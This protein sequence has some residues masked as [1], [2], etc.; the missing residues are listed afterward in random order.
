MCDWVLFGPQST[1]KVNRTRQDTVQMCEEC[2][3][4]HANVHASTTINGRRMSKKKITLLCVCVEKKWPRVGGRMMGRDVYAYMSYP[5]AH[6]RHAP[7]HIYIMLHRTYTLCFIARPQ[8]LGC[9]S[10]QVR[11]VI[12]FLLSSL[13]V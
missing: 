4:R 11:E 1:V 3:L 13:Y 10:P 5:I 7:S 12:F 6:T 2:P 9:S 8:S